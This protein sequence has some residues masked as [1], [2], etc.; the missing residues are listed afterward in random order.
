M[1]GPTQLCSELLSLFSVVA[2]SSVCGS[3]VLLGIEQG[4][5][6]CKARSLTPELSVQSEELEI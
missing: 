5:A 1:L 3:Q 4:S 2:L 6:T